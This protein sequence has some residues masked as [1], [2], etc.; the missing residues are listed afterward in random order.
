M[1]NSVLMRT[2]FVVFVACTVLIMAGG[3]SACGQQDDRDAV[4]AAAEHRI[5]EL[6]SRVERL[7]SLMFNTI[8]LSV[9]DAERRLS[10]ARRTQEQNQR[11]YFRGLLSHI[12]VQRGRYEL[13][14]AERELDLARAETGQRRIIGDIGVMEAEFNLRSAEDQLTRARRG[15]ARGLVSQYQLDLNAK[16]VER[17]TQALQLARDRLAAVSPESLTEPPAKS[18]GDSEPESENT[19]Q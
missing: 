4:L 7:E 6:E 5:R 8:Q 13:R 1:S 11:L 18:A 14:R 2:R 9:F 17:A 19:D 16:E 12:E 15:L 3:L 10:R